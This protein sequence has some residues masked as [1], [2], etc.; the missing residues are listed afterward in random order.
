[1]DLLDRTARVSRREAPKLS[2]ILRSLALI[3]TKKIETGA[4]FPYVTTSVSKMRRG[5]RVVE[6]ISLEN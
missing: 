5:G 4:G 1:M 3:L 6:C 2:I